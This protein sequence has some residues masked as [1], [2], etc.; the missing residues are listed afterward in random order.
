ME[1]C[2][3]SN[4]QVQ[5]TTYL[6]EKSIVVLHVK[7][8]GKGMIPYFKCYV[9]LDP[10]IQFSTIMSSKNTTV[11]RCLAEFIID[12]NKLRDSFEIVT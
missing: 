1:L 3:I 2:N 12:A 9:I 6:L 10:E 7:R 4:S 8:S 11:I 5:S